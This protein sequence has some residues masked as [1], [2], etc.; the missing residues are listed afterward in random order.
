MSKKYKSPKA[1]A[2]ERLRKLYFEILERPFS[3]ELLQSLRKKP[4]VSESPKKKVAKGK[5]D[6]EI[7]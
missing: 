3:E 1:G 2:T 5:F 4:E 7:E 6:A